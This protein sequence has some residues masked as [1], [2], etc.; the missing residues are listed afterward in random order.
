M[1]DEAMAVAV[2]KEGKHIRLGNMTQLN[3]LTH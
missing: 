2:W 3:T 1:C